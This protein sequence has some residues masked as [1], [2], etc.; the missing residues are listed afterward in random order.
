M[1]LD[2]YLAPLLSFILQV[3]LPWEISMPQGSEKEV[4][5]HGKF[6]VPC[7]WQFRSITSHTFS[8]CPGVN[9]IKKG[10]SEKED[11]KHILAQI[12]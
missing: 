6:F 4:W 11:N 9:R 8:A 10:F 5:R 3:Y 7:S 1:L 12:F 2:K